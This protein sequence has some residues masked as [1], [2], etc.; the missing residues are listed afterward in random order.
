MIRKINPQATIKGIRGNVDTR[1]AKLDRG[2]YDSIVLAKAGLNRLSINR[3]D[4]H[5]Q[6]FNIFIPAPAQGALGIQCRQEDAR[7]IPILQKVH[8]HETAICVAL[9]RRFLA[10]IQGGCNVAAGCYVYRIAEHYQ[11]SLFLDRGGMKQGHISFNDLSE[12]YEA[13]LELVGV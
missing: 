3:I 10:A 7:I 5:P 8:H 13:M 12:G 11:A 2:E 1:L 9:E 4:A 6:D